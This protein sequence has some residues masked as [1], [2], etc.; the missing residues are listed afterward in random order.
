M[1]R[2][3][4]LIV[5]ENLNTSLNTNKIG[6]KTCPPFQMYNLGSLPLLPPTTGNYNLLHNSHL[7]HG[8]GQCGKS[9]YKTTPPFPHYGYC[10]V[11]LFTREDHNLWTQAECQD[12]GS[13]R[14]QMV[15]PPSLHSHILYD[16]LPGHLH[17]SPSSNRNKVPAPGRHGCRL[18]PPDG[19]Q[20]RRRVRVLGQEVG[21]HGP[22]PHHRRHRGRGLRAGGGS[23]RETGETRLDL[24]LC[25]SKPVVG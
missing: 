18:H 16:Q 17:I 8:S 2:F 9:D 12:P 14:A 7:H 21:L 24:F 13:S 4:S 10:L 20:S 3:L 22:P 25:V 19:A 6:V 11:H 5:S 15:S 1:S 23:A